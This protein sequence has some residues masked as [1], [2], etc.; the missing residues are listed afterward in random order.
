MRAAGL[1]YG[2]LFDG[3]LPPMPPPL[4]AW[5]DKHFLNEWHSTL[6][7]H[8]DEKGELLRVP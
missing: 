7:K 8:R 3:S 4:S 5:P 1:L 6:A 2:K